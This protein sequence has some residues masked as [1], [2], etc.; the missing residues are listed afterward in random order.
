[1]FWNCKRLSCVLVA[2]L[3]KGKQLLWLT[4]HAHPPTITSRVGHLHTPLAAPPALGDAHALL[5]ALLR[6]NLPAALSQVQHWQVQVFVQVAC[7][8]S[9]PI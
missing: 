1:M 7:R 2:C 8:L 3:Y 6:A 5:L 4:L 9:K